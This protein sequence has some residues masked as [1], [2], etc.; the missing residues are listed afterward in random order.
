MDVDG[1]NKRRL[2]HFNV[3]GF[4]EY[5]PSGIVVADFDWLKDSRRIVAKVRIQSDEIM[6]GETIRMIL[7]GP[8][9]KSR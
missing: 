9:Q 8:R 1:S 2:T 3:K 7:F 6:S 5:D 4:P